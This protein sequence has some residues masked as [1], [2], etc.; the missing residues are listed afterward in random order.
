MTSSF[1]LLWN[2][3]Q[4]KRKSST[5]VDQFTFKFLII[6][7]KQCHLNNNAKCNNNNNKN[8]LGLN[9]HA[10]ICVLRLNEQT[11]D[12]GQCDELVFP[13]EMKITKN[14]FVINE[15]GKKRTIQFNNLL[16]K[17]R[18]NQHS[19]YWMS[20]RP[21]NAWK[22]YSLYV[23]CFFVPFGKLINF[24]SFAVCTHCTLCVCRRC[25]C[26]VCC[27]MHFTL[28]LAVK[29]QQ[30]CNYCE[31]VGRLLPQHQKSIC[32]KSKANKFYTYVLLFVVVLLLHST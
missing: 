15:N 19:I 17:K 29:V 7:I 22:F 4:S 31:W 14:N 24:F 27:T 20:I 10:I 13:I 2:F 12:D 32:D 1:F 25:F 21:I 6:F 3:Q 30:C 8:P 26:A 18:A 28:Y 5:T 23:L 16:S 9:H 11:A